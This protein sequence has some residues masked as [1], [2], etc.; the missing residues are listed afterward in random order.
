M[1]KGFAAVVVA[2]VMITGFAFYSNVFAQDKKPV[3]IVL[4]MNSHSENP[5]RMWAGTFQLAWNELSE[6]FVKGDVIFEGDEQQADVVELNKKSFRDKDI[7]PN[8][9]Y[10][11]FGK[12][13]PALKKRIG[14]NIMQ[15]FKE[16]SDILDSL[17]WKKGKDKYT[18]YAMLKKDFK[19]D[20]AFSKLEKE[21][22]GQNPEPVQYYGINSKTSKALDKNVTVLFYNSDNDFAVSLAT[23]GNDVVYLYRT[24]DD[25]TFEEYYSDMFAKKE[26][27]TGETK[28]SENDE[29]KYPGINLF[30]LTE[31][32]SLENKKIKGTKMLI[33]KAIETVKFKMDNKGVML[34]SEAGIMIEMT[35]LPLPVEAKPRY[36]YFNDNYVLFLQEQNKVKPYFA[37]RVADAA[38]LNKTAQNK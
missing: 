6:K 31:F 30:N 23:H 27:Y 16:K 10:V 24:D 22:F 26:S 15:K 9:Y 2:I 37:I 35:A 18:V 36:F 4:T 13:S 1:K 7:S 28:F 29:L 21:P 25:K 17:D 38:A 12:T 34:K 20:R 11:T 19:F 14:E 33:S 3:D 32:A 5:N 8:A